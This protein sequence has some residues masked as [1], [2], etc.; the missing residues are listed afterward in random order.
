MK[1][2]YLLLL[3]PI[4][5][6]SQVGINTTN[7]NAQLD[8]QST[9]QVSPSNTDGLL[10]P[11]VDTFPAV[12]PTIA[13]QGMLVYLTTTVGSNTSGFYYWDNPSTTWVPIGDNSK[14]AWKLSGNNVTASDFIGTINDQDVLFKR[15]N[16]NAG[17]VG[18][19]NTSFGFL[20]GNGT[21]VRSAAFGSQ[22]LQTQGGADNS[23]FGYQ[24]MNGAGNGSG[25]A[26]FGS[27][28]LNLNTTGAL[29]AAMGFEALRN[30]TTGSGNTA[31]GGN[32][33]K[34]NTTGIQN[35][36]VGR[37]ALLSNT[38]AGNNT[39]VGTNALSQNTLGSSNTAVGVSALNA[40]LL[41]LNNVAIGNSSLLNNTSGL[42]NSALGFNSLFNNTLGN[43]NIGIGTESLNLNT[44][45]SSNVAIGN[46]ALN[47]TNNGSLNT[48]IGSNVQA[49]GAGNT[50]LT[51]ATAIGAN[52][53][54]ASNNALVLGS[55][56]G[57]NGATSSVNVGI[58][59]ATPLDRLH[60]EGNIRIVDGNQGIGKV[61]TSDDNGTATWQNASTNAWSL[62]G[63][64][65]TDSTTN[66]IGTTDNKSF[67]LRTNN[68]ER[69]NVTN[70][71]KTFI[72][73]AIP[74]NDN[75]ADFSKVV[76]GSNDTDNDITLRSSGNDIPAFNI[77]K[78]NGTIESPTLFDNGEIGSLR[79]WRYT[80]TGIDGYISAGRIV[81][82]VSPTG[83]KLIMSADQGLSNTSIILQQTGEVGIGTAT[84][85]SKLHISDGTIGI[86]PF[87]GSKLVL[88]SN[89]D[90]Y[91]QFLTPNTLA[92]TGSG[93][94]FGTTTGNIRGGVIFSAQAEKIDFR[95]GGNTTRMTI[96]NSGLVG[97]GTTSPVRKLHVSNG[98]SGGTS[99]G[100][101]GILLESN[102]TVYQHYLTPST[103]ENGMLFGSELASIN[104]GII[105]NNLATTNGIQFRTGGNT[106]RMVLTDTGRLGIG[107]LVP[108]GQFEL[109]QDQGR[110][111]L[112]NTWTITS[113][114]RLKTIDG[115]YQK[116]LNEIIQLKP[117]KYHYKNTEK[118]TFDSQVLNKQ[119]Y[120]FLAQE[121]QQIFSEAVGTDED[122][123][124]NF[125]I[126][127]I[128]IAS[129]N[130]FKDLNTKYEE[131]KTENKDLKEKLQALIK[132]IETLEKN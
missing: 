118:K 123:Y 119:A 75:W 131:L 20:S 104:G 124:L 80:G 35:T 66:F 45:G 74:T 96:L 8:I 125:D 76:V 85:A 108:G 101:T 89:E 55:I 71:G 58:G 105:F 10:I 18:A 14:N 52:A 2:L 38:T 49:H 77:L 100:N 36:A 120:G 82:G 1:K 84:P 40:N 11:K 29:N 31:I 72:G 73:N 98:V 37:F 81:S 109:S 60:V 48:G 121:V 88:E 111:P 79:F 12:N 90:A 67:S 65:G 110:K 7:P 61:L 54:V 6:F 3:Y 17:K 32:A 127:P 9:N 59:T 23:A 46:S 24:S 53:L 16:T 51:N 47:V 126:H 63:N 114:A 68:I 44:T 129:V 28:S 83:T 92:S 25:N 87:S 39:A 50:N 128:L 95:T 21:G 91:H 107:T 70:A 27:F 86:T 42:Q 19:V 15:F 33:L 34:A 56:N 78:S 41:G 13:Q 5:A 94:L 93:L 103:S 30:N 64:S 57:V 115:L 116:G 117:I 130:A 69:I 4:L 122:G 132:R 97:I 99:N 102:G 62:T 26:A 43:N 112:S 106:N 22:S 113:D